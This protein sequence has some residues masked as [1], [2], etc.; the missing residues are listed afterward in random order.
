MANTPPTNDAHGETKEHTT[1]ST[2][3]NTHPP[4]DEHAA[5]LQSEVVRMDAELATLHGELQSVAER[6]ATTVED[7]SDPLSDQ[8]P[9]SSAATTVAQAVTLLESEKAAVETSLV[10]WLQVDSLARRLLPPYFV[11][12]QGVIKRPEHLIAFWGRIFSIL[13]PSPFENLRLRW[14]CRMFR[15]ALPSSLS[16]TLI[17][18]GK[19]SLRSSLTTVILPNSLKTIEHN[20]FRGCSSLTSVILPDSLKI[21]GGN[22]FR[23]C[24]SLTSVVLPDSLVC[25]CNDAFLECTSLASVSIPP[26]QS[27][28][29]RIDNC[30]FSSSCKIDHRPDSVSSELFSEGSDFSGEE[31]SEGSISSGEEEYYSD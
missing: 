29:F 4:C 5:F 18:G 27:M 25:I 21:I 7:G 13:G 20:A 22:A 26:L 19:F 15:D 30:G 12:P 17:E 6:L 11:N 3:S 24:S 2:D 31:E 23:G 14:I 9:L 10:E 28:L 16:P 8:E 1:A